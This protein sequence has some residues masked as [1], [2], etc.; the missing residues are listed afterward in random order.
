VGP[1]GLG[2]GA[3][4]DS[5]RASVGAWRRRDGTSGVFRTGA[6]I[7][8]VPTPREPAPIVREGVGGGGGGGAVRPG[9]PGPAPDPAWVGPGPASRCADSEVRRAPRGLGEARD[10]SSESLP[11]HTRA[12]RLAGARTRR[13]GGRADPA[14]RSESARRAAGEL[15]NQPRAGLYSWIAKGGVDCFVVHQL[16]ARA[17]VPP[18]KIADAFWVNGLG[19]TGQIIKAWHNLAAARQR[20]HD[21]RRPATRTGPP[22]RG[23]V[24]SDPAALPS[25][26]KPVAGGAR[27]LLLAGPEVRCRGGPKPV[28]GHRLG[29]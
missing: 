15:D 13:C 17:R 5:D 19:G 29:R 21:F 20:A 9:V 10:A 8:H 2:P 12:H 16:S 14:A 27:S 3:R 24:P 4:S 6:G 11:R 18:V 22:Q 1:I 28:A 26:A 7:G 23:P 25:W